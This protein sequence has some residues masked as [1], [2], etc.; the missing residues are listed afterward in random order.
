MLYR[1]LVLM[2]TTLSLVACDGGGT[3]EGELPAP[4]IYEEPDSPEAVLSGGA[5]EAAVVEALGRIDG[6]DAGAWYDEYLSL[7]SRGDA[8]CPVTF[9]G[10]DTQYE[11]GLYFLYWQGDCVSD[12][13]VMF[14]GRSYHYDYADVVGED[15]GILNGFY[16]DFSGGLD[17]ATAAAAGA[18]AIASYRGD[19]PGY[20]YWQMIIEGSFSSTRDAFADTWLAP[21][22][23][24]RP[25]I[26]KTAIAGGEAAGL[27]AGSRVGMLDGGITGLDGDLDTV[28]VADL[29]LMSPELSAC[30][31]PGGTVSVRDADGN[32][33]DILFH[34]PEDFEDDT[35]DLALC[36][37]C[38]D[39]WFRGQRLDDACIDF[40]TL[41]DFEEQPW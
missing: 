40:G 30:E 20:S 16:I 8:G 36:D 38:G 3:L 22:A 41:I 6:V 10:D 34:G 23:A 12:D 4:Y 19:Y 18:G 31:E 39:V 1:T 37:G 27:P 25:A 9:T 14:T 2:G 24:L 29:F 7:A 13:G 28:S 33:Y 35:V 5:L 26:V 21:Q 11:E 15:G 17:D 32:W